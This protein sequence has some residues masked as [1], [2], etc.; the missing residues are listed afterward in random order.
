MMKLLIYLKNKEFVPATIVVD[1][2]FEK[3]LNQFT[4]EN[5]H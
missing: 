1:S 5:I 3:T 2:E 4:N